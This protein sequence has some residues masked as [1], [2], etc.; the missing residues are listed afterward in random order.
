VGP[1]NANSPGAI[2]AHEQWRPVLKVVLPRRL[3]SGMT[4]FDPLRSSVVAASAPRIEEEHA[5]I[6]HRVW[7]N[8]ARSETWEVLCTE[9]E[10]LMR[11]Q[12]R[13]VHKGNG[14]KQKFSERTVLS[15][16]N[17]ALSS[18]REGGARSSASLRGCG[19]AHATCVA[20]EPTLTPRTL[21][22]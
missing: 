2:G 8:L 18:T 1:R 5:N 6:S 15:L 3:P 7:V 12:A 21:S 19:K 13:P 20:I 10:A 16:R 4:H 11:T 14:R 22:K 9:P 17:N